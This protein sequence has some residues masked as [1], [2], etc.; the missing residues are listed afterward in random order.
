MFKKNELL[1]GITLSGGEP[2]EQ[3]Q[4]MYLIASEIHKLRKNIWTYTGYTM[5]ELLD[6]TDEFVQKLLQET[7]HLVDGKFEESKKNLSLRF[8]GSEN[9]RIFQNQNG[10]WILIKEK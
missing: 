9:Q 6:N 8:R 1:S 3:A 4:A 10:K 5:E 2:F 7:D